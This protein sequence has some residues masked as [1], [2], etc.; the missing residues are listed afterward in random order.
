VLEHFCLAAID[1]HQSPARVAH[2]ERLK[3]LVQ[4]QDSAHRP[5]LQLRIKKS[6]G[7]CAPL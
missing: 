4:H 6:V 3:V 2:I 1:Q 5:Y 7:I